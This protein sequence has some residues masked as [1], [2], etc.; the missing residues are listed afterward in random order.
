MQAYWERFQDTLARLAADAEAPVS[1]MLERVTDGGQVPV[2]E[3]LKMLVAEDVSPFGKMVSEVAEK[4]PTNTR[5]LIG[6]ICGKSASAI[7]GEDCGYVRGVL[8]AAG[9]LRCK[10][11]ELK[12][13]LPGRTLSLP[14]LTDDHGKTEV[15][16]ALAELS[17]GL[18][19]SPEHIAR[20]VLDL[21]FLRGSE[22]SEDANPSAPT[23]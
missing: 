15:E 21:L 14:A 2:D 8:E 11:G 3:V 7:Q 19:L 20:L 17:Q 10:G 12:V 6:A 16:R 13:M 9:Q 5:E 4:K 18:G 1:S 23:P 22:T